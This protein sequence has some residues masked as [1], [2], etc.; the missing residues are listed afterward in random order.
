MSTGSSR[1]SEYGTT[2]KNGQIH[3]LEEH[4]VGDYTNEYLH[5]NLGLCDLSPV[6]KRDYVKIAILDKNKHAQLEITMDRFTT[7]LSVNQQNSC[8]DWKKAEKYDLREF[9]TSGEEAV[10]KIWAA[11]E[12]GSSPT[13]VFVV[14]APEKQIKTGIQCFESSHWLR[15]ERSCNPNVMEVD[16][17]D[18]S[19]WV[20]DDERFAPPTCH[21]GCAH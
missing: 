13:K 16:Q 21:G 17:I 6:T 5:L 11:S 9:F 14:D 12:T 18:M 3:H 10:I 7:S 15:F 4:L 19:H 8:G 20:P 1:A 2:I